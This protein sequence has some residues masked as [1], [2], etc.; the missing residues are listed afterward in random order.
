VLALQNPEAQSL[1][2]QAAVQRWLLALLDDAVAAGGDVAG[3]RA[4]VAG[5]GSGPG[6][7]KR[8]A[9]AIERVPF[10]EIR[11]FDSLLV[12]IPIARQSNDR[13]IPFLDRER[14]LNAVRAGV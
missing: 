1:S 7:G 14:W 5:R 8:P 4:T 10:P 12:E 6:A 3:R 11:S 13:D 9:V 2:W